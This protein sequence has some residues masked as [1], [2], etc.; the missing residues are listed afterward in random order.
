ML[1]PRL[2]ISHTRLS[3]VI[4]LV[5][6]PTNDIVGVHLHRVTLIVIFEVEV[7]DDAL[8]HLVAYHVFFV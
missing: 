4:D 5:D 6:T 3:M 7:L 1:T 2:Y 8:E